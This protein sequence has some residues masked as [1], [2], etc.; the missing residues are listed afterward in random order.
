M[1]EARV[2]GERTVEDISAQYGVSLGFVHKWSRT[3]LAYRTLKDK[4]N[5]PVSMAVF[6]SRSN[7]PKKVEA[8]VPDYVRDRIVEC[9][10]TLRF[11]GSAKIRVWIRE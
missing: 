1:G 5:D 8:K 6:E 11:A 4:T 9:R 7:R 2:R 3:Y 10:T